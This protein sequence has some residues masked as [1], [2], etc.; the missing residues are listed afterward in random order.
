MK[1]LIAS[2]EAFP[3]C[4]TGGLADVVG[5]LSQSISRLDGV[6][7]VL[8]FLP[9]YR[10][11]GGGAFSLKAV[12]GN[13]LIPVA[14]KLET[15]SLYHVQWGRISVYFIENQKYFDRPSMYRTA[16]GDYEDNDERFIFF[17]RAVLEGAKF[18]GFKP[19]II[20]CHDWQTGLIPAYLKTLYR[21]DAF[22]AKAKT[23]F[24]IHNIAYQGMFP[25]E[26]FMKAGFNW[27][28]YTP[29][30]LE[31]YGGINFLKA[32]IVFSDRI[33][34][35]SPSYS[36][37]IQAGA[38]MGKG[39]EGVL[40]SR[41]NNLFG[42][43]NGI[44]NEI[45]DPAMDT[46]IYRGYDSKTYWRGKPYCKKSFQKEM[47]LSENKNI[48]LAGIVSR[49]DWQKGIDLITQ[50]AWEFLDKIQFV[51]L[52]VGDQQITAMI[53]ELAG[54]NSGKVVF[55]NEF[56]EE[57]AHKIYAASDIF[58]MPSR[59]EPC[60]LSQMIA[61]RY[62]SLPIVNRTGGL[63]DTVYYNPEDLPSSNGFAFDGPTPANLKS[64]LGHVVSVY[65]SKELFNA[66]IK[67]AMKTDF[68]WTKSSS[69]YMKIFKMLKEN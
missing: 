29:D 36:L 9:K 56:N 12:G 40:K 13:F 53:K 6:E 62:G 59:F 10:N 45:W 2:S 4:K 25:R 43:L 41:S 52:G 47:G 46:F 42:I 33:T 49:L 21:I 16:N 69:E 34:T 58:L 66:M 14:H 63:K 31:F 17:S 65:S 55:I 32:G 7:E 64:M 44:D 1:I 50:V 39:L 60:G 51:F 67:N 20:H 68:S 27:M 61:M 8:L 37:E 30:K 22:F 54:N 28:D 5:S 23:V 18:L 3:F 24:T 26:T 19:D 15:A 57:K 11:I 35:V 48:L 38:D